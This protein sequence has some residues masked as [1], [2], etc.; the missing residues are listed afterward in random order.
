MLYLQGRVPQP[1]INGVPHMKLVRLYVRMGDLNEEWN[2]SAQNQTMSWVEWLV[3]K[4]MKLEAEQE[5][6]E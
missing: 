5:S 2:S 3:D 4:I 1:S 6:H